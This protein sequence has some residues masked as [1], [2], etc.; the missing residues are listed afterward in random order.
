MFVFVSV[1]Y[2]W[3]YI[4]FPSFAFIAFWHILDT[5]YYTVEPAM[6]L[7]EATLPFPQ[8]AFCTQ[9][10]TSSWQPR[11]FKCHFSCVSQGWLLITGSTVL[12]IL[13]GMLSWKITLSFCYYIYIVIFENKSEVENKQKASFAYTD[14]MTD[15][16]CIYTVYKSDTIRPNSIIF[17]LAPLFVHNMST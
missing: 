13:Y 7:L 16:S 2:C 8:M 17:I 9:N 11:A 1:Y 4:N 14:N 6:S 3:F 5:F 15:I 12:Q 10:W